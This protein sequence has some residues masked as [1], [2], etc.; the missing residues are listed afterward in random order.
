V[1]Q[2]GRDCGNMTDAN[3]DT[4]GIDFNAWTGFFGYKPTEVLKYLLHSPCRIT[5]LYSGNQFGKNETIS[6]DY[7]LRLLGK[8]PNKK[9]NIRKE[10][11]IRIF[12]FASQ[13]LPGEKEEIEVRNTQ[14][15]VLKRRLPSM[16]I[17][18]EITARKPVMTIRAQDGGTV[19]FEFVS[20]SQD[21]QAGA[22]VQRRS[23]WVDE[24]CSRDFFEEQ[25]PRLLAADGDM[26]FSLTPVPGS[27]GWEFDELYAR[28]RV[29]YRTQFV[30]DR[31][32]ARTGED[33]PEV[34]YTES[35]EDICVIM[36][37]TD[38]N[39]M[40]A[41]LA[42]KKSLDLGVPIT[43]KEYIDEI[44]SIYD[45]ED[46]IDARR[47]GLF[48][49]LSGKIYK[50]FSKV[51][52]IEYDRYFRNGI[53][54]EWKHFRGIDYHRANPWACVW[55]S[56]SPQDEIFVWGNFAPQPSKMRVSEIARQVSEMSGDYKFSLNLIDPLAQ[57][58]KQESNRSTVED[59]NEFF[60]E[61]RKNDIGTGGYWQSWD[62]HGV[63]GRE[64]LIK[65][66]LNSVEVGKPFM[67]KIQKW[68]HD[69]YLPTI[70]F[71]N[72]CH[73]IIESMKN[74][75]MD[76]WATREMLTKNDA[77]EKEQA[78]WSHF[79]ITIE[80]LLKNPIVSNSRWGSGD[81]SPLRPKLYAVGGR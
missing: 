48:R 61:L 13:T 26:I 8:H 76:D 21:V 9:K 29:I 81:S 60:R 44:F 46:V 57:E 4:S 55:M 5:C 51:H 27:M 72:N 28:A 71:T 30:R 32:K 39:P 45:D 78:R 40:Y 42:E 12:R 79:P 10:D 73:L 62:T 41:E 38:D 59:M 74:W 49:Q 70:W 19:Q 36:A 22:G 54:H 6:Y 63:R 11:K 16:F 68:G 23:C 18:K 33:V 50:S 65:R 75:R 24:S 7:I 20:F 15:P 67:N 17:E 80:C 2:R 3:T 64:E 14:Y 66:I 58:K 52:V 25:I 69:Q 31:I 34:E 47:F 1:V 35:K 53:P 56:V 77:K 37:A 43:A